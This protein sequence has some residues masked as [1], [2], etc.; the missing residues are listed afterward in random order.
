MAEQPIDVVYPWLSAPWRRLQGYRHEQRMPQAVLIVGRQ[1]LGKRRLAESFAALLLCQQPGIM[2]CGQCPS[3]CLLA[4]QTHPD[5]LL[6]QP[7]EPG[8]GIAIDTVRAL[9][10]KLS[11]K[12]QYSAYRVVL[13]D[14]AHAMNAAAA[15]ALLKTLEE[16]PERTLML[17]LSAMPSHIPAT[18]ISRCQRLP[19]APPAREAALAWLRTQAPDLAVE[20]ALAAACD[21]P[22]KAL[23]LA[24]AG[25]LEQ[26][27][28][29]F[30]LWPAFVQDRAEPVQAAEKLTKIPLDTLIDWLYSWA[31]DV[32]KLAFAATP[33]QLVNGDRIA[34]LQAA[35]RHMQPGRIHGFIEILQYNKRQLAINAQLNR[36]LLLE[37]ICIAWQRLAKPSA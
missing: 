4:A 31:C 9:I 7:A 15:N 14:P 23:D 2:A 12:P 24:Q 26:R 25:L 13:L 19:V 20:A 6:L 5:Y 27:E 35:A 36:P 33:E 28:R 10:A 32:L 34:Q 18:L 16:P 21:A 1:G 3:C 11:L 8:K 22:L 37:E 29:L 17:L 30:D